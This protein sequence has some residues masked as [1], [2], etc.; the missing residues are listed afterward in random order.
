MYLF[1][2]FNYPK[3]DLIDPLDGE[4][5]LE[6]YDKMIKEMYKTKGFF[7]LIKKL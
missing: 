4:I 6:D 2:D 1:Y 7:G 5:R 3:L